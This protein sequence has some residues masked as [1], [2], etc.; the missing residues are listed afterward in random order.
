MTVTLLQGNCI[1]ILKT[2]PDRSV[3]CCVTSPPFY[4][5]RDYGT[6]FW[7][8]GDPG[9]NHSPARRNGANSSTLGGGR[10]TSEHKAEGYKSTCGKCGAIRMDSQ[11]GLEETPEAYIEKLVQ[12]FREAWRVLKDNGTLW[13]NLGDSYAGSSMSG[14][15]QT[16]RV[17]GGTA[18]LLQQHED[19]KE[20]KVKLPDGLKPK[21][22]I[23]IP[24]M[25]AFALR[26][27]GWYLR[28]DIIWNKPNPM[29][30]SVRDRCTKSHEYIFLLT[31]SAKYYYDMEAIKE[32]AA[33]ASYG[34]WNQDIENQEGS[35]RAN[36][37]AKTNGKMKAVGKP[38]LAYSF[39]RTV[40]EEPPPGQ[41][42]QHRADREDIEYS[43]VRNKRSVWTVTTKPYKDA[44]FAVYPPELIEPCILAGSRVG[45]VILDP[46]NGSGTT[47]EVALRYR[48]SYIGIELNPAYI[49]LTERRFAKVQPVLFD[50]KL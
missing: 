7:D 32:P 22:M 28:Q 3:Q 35:A 24:W 45:D 26:A 11:I 30:E 16:K 5:L 42:N 49:K 21:D 38:N 1:D 23:G 40:S 46:F 18:K 4:G 8:G 20:V 50:G 25:V 37:G 43:G 44:H 47:G 2:L 9:C 34:R 41:P 17:G 19:N 29:P 33:D 13:L 10:V 27:D 31:K 6:A 14:G 48:R 39:K 12:V 36:G 15:D